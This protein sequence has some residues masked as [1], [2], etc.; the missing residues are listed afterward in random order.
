VGAIAGD[1]SAGKHS[2][3]VSAGVWKPPLFDAQKTV[4]FPR[5]SAFDALTV[6]RPRDLQG[7]IFP[8]DA[9]QIV[10]NCSN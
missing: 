6:H 2:N 5:I 10:V 7:K 9:C 3:W 4:R 1:A 8:G